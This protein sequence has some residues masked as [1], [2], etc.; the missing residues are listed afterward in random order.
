M[1]LTISALECT[2]G[3]RE[4]AA[5][6]PD[7]AGTGTCSAVPDPGDPGPDKDG[8]F[9]RRMDLNVYH[10]LRASNPSMLRVGSAFGL[11][12]QT[13][14]WGTVSVLQCRT[15]TLFAHRLLSQHTLTTTTHQP[16]TSLTTEQTLTPRDLIL[17][18]AN[19]SPIWGVIR[20]HHE[21]FL[22]WKEHEDIASD[23]EF[24]S[25]ESGLFSQSIADSIPMLKLARFIEE[26]P[27]KR[28]F[29]TRRGR[30]YIT[31]KLQTLG[32]SPTQ[33]GDRKQSWDEWNRHGLRS[34]IYRSYSQD[35]P[36]EEQIRI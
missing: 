36:R 31:Q 12:R 21:S 5:P 19:V 30:Q 26:M 18:L 1:D 25:N 20:L 4:G 28:Y 8:V 33:I 29:I 35:W 34:H 22:L 27:G 23:P 3:V 24:H 17:S 6:A 11:V 15:E 14:G 2:R 7:R 16:L 13:C 10:V 32:I 9:R